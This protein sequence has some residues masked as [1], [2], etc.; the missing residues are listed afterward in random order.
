MDS[1]P[2]NTT[3]NRKLLTVKGGRI[4]RPRTAFLCLKE[5]INDAH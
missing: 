1:P 3:G 5:S 2:R 4:G